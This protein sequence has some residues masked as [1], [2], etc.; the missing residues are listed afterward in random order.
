MFLAALALSCSAA[1]K[2]QPASID[3][4][5]VNKVAEPSGDMDKDNAPSVLT[6]E[7][8]QRLMAAVTK[9]PEPFLA[10]RAPNQAP[11][12]RAQV[13]KPISLE[14]AIPGLLRWA[15][16]TVA[17]FVV[18]LPGGVQNAVPVDAA[19]RGQPRSRR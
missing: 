12:L 15:D 5:P 13:G 4:R 6:P 8:A 19:S 1:C 17:S 18:R 16:A 3:Q 14:L 11:S 10:V 2:T 7:V 9:H